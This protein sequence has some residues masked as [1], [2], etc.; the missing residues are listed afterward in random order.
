MSGALQK[1]LSSETMELLINP[2]IQISLRSMIIG[3]DDLIVFLVTH[4]DPFNHNI[5]DLNVTHNNSITLIFN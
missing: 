5:Y 4:Q 2:G 1:I 3:L